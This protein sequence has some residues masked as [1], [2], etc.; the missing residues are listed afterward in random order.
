MIRINDNLDLKKVVEFSMKISYNYK[1]PNELINKSIKIN[2]MASYDNLV[3]K[4]Y[5]SEISK[6]NNSIKYINTSNNIYYNNLSSN[7]YIIDNNKLENLYGKHH[8]V[9]FI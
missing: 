4:T 3:D 7:V 6:I 8:M 2:Y 5:N 9:V 1:H